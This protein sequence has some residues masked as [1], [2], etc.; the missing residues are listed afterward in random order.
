MEDDQA[1]NHTVNEYRMVPSSPDRPTKILGESAPGGELDPPSQ[2]LGES[3]PAAEF[4][5]GGVDEKACL[6]SLEAG[7]LTTHEA[8][9]EA[10]PSVCSSVGTVGLVEQF[11]LSD[12]PPSEIP[13]GRF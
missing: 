13:F 2:I 12:W 4:D 11:D 7:V 6:T 3:A 5:S 1:P 10:R 9:P 8:R